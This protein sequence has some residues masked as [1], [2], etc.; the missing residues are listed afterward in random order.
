MNAGSADSFLRR[1]DDGFT[2][3]PAPNSLWR[4]TFVHERRRPW[5][6]TKQPGWWFIRGLLTFCLFSLAACGVEPTEQFIAV[7]GDPTLD[8]DYV[9]TGYGLLFIPAQSSSDEPRWQISVP[10]WRDATTRPIIELRIDLDAAQNGYLGADAGPR[11]VGVDA[12]AFALDE[13][14]VIHNMDRGL[15][16]VLSRLTVRV[17]MCEPDP[18]ELYCFLV[19]DPT[20]LDLD[21]AVASET[22]TVSGS[23]LLDHDPD[24]DSYYAGVS[25]TPSHGA[26]P[27]VPR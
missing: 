17:E 10:A 8:G 27:P 19:H 20:Q 16:T 5:P 21:V 4:V 11:D 22:I 6:P 23:V 13:V 12:A 26:A 14:S 15:L 9:A 7:R 18:P 1:C 3:T 2:D 24:L 25:S